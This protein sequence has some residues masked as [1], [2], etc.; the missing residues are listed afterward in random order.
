MATLEE[1]C[2]NNALPKALT[3]LQFAAG[4]RFQLKQEQE[5]AVRDL[6]AGKDVLVVLPTGFGKSLIYQT[7]VRARDYQLAGKAAI[8]VISPLNSIISDQLDDMELQGYSAVD[9]SAI[10]LEDIRK[11]TFKIAF[12]TAEMVRKKPFMEI[13]K[14]SSSPLHQNIAAIVVDESHTVETWTG[15][16]YCQVI[17]LVLKGW[18]TADMDRKV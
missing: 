5:V 18:F 7:F 17:I 2:I 16:R 9:A 4:R 8:I 10:S 11:C 3:D 1:A 15:K 14:D 12:A 13:L 6:Q